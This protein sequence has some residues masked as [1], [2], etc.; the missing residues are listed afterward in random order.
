M[1]VVLFFAARARAQLQIGA[2]PWINEG[3]SP[4]G[5]AIANDVVVDLVKRANLELVPLAACTEAQCTDLA[6]VAG[7]SRYLVLS[8]QS[9]D[10]QGLKVRIRVVDS[11]QNKTLAARV[12]FIKPDDRRGTREA[13]DLL[14]KEM[15]FHLFGPPMPNHLIREAQAKLGQPQPVETA[16]RVPPAPVPVPVRYEPPPEP[17]HAAPAVVRDPVPAAAPVPVALPPRAPAY[18]PPPP[19]PEPVREPPPPPAA[20][21]RTPEPPK[22]AAAPARAPEPEPEPP[23]KS[24]PPPQIVIPDEI[25]VPYLP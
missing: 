5:V 12:T 10:D 4:G 1:F 17:V 2:P 9:T 3:A 20:P 21:A 13:F 16:V 11:V 22:P 14:F 6:R 24:S 19:K 23:D 15:A 25:S 8:M 7:I 18:T